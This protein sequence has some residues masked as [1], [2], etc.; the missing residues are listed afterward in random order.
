MGCLFVNVDIKGDVWSPSLGWRVL[1]RRR[2]SRTSP[3]SL[4][5]IEQTA[6]VASVLF[7]GCGIDQDVNG[8]DHGTGL[9]LIVNAQ[10]L[11]PELKVP[12]FRRHWQ[13]FQDL[14]GSVSV[15]ESLGIK[16]RDTWDFDGALGFV[17]VDDF[18]R[19]KFEHC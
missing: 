16:G 6:D 9:P 13:W 5:N 2:P 12:S 10:D 8:L 17:E 1:L 7:P 3:V 15:D 4:T 11:G 18:L 19:I 14:D